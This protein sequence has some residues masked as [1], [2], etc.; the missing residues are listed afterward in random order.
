MLI[1]LFSSSLVVVFALLSVGWHSSALAQVYAQ[2]GPVPLPPA[3]LAPSHS[4]KLAA[5]LDAGFSSNLT[6]ILHDFSPWNMFLEA[7]LVVKIVMIL[8]TFASIAAWTVWL[9]KNLELFLAN[10]RACSALAV[11]TRASSL[12]VAKTDLS[13]R[14]DPVSHLVSMVM[15]E[16]DR[17]KGLSAE[18]I[19]TRAGI[20]LNRLEA[21]TN[22]LMARR[23][24]MLATIGAT[25]PFI[26]LFG[27]V[28]GIMN[29]FVGISH[30]KATNL[31]VVA[32]GIAEALLATAC[33][34]IAAVPAVVFYNQLARR[35]SGY[36]AT[37]GDAAAEIMQH[38]SRE[39]ERKTPS[40][41][42]KHWSEDT[43]RQ[44]AE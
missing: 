38:L 41:E 6:T 12:A 36:R 29:S 23:I 25:A 13:L 40:S 43:L 37:L 22:R 26:G 16:V 5:K 20:L 7:S 10:R 31:A 42:N 27:T 4:L 8:L 9:T 33:G 11:I 30:S 35:I 3:E 17:S 44:A 18:G 15:R 34:L 2:G 19:M 1:E 21:K 14:H 24:G 28:W 32:P 39:L